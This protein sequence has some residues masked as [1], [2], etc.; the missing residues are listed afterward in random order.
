MKNSIDT[1]ENRTRDLPSCSAMPHTTATHCAPMNV[2]ERYFYS[3]PHKWQ[4]KTKN[5][6]ITADKRKEIW[7][8]I[9]GMQK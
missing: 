6:Q 9:Y 2:Y 8:R 4:V 1:I 3:M 5:N 7:Y